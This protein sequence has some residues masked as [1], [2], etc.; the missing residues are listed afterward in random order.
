MGTSTIIP[1]QARRSLPLPHRDNNAAHCCCGCRRPAAA[2]AA[3]ARAR[4]TVMDGATTDPCRCVTRG[5]C[6]FMNVV[7][8]LLD[9]KHRLVGFQGTAN[10]GIH[11]LQ[12]Q[13]MY[14]IRSGVLNIIR[15]T[16]LI[17]VPH[18]S[19]SDLAGVLRASRACTMAR[20]TDALHARSRN[21]RA[22]DHGLPHTHTTSIVSTLSLHR[23]GQP[24]HLPI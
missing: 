13:C 8:L 16:G 7:G 5:C 24:T 12:Q 20:S 17:W 3:R 14:V 22:F 18:D 11:T 6:C 21:V 15:V 4:V 10:L 2:A 23:L 1:T 19:E 9:T